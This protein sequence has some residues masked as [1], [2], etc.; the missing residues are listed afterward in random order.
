MHEV[1]RSG[2]WLYDGTASRPVFIV[3]LDY[4]FWHEI[5]KADGLLDSG[6]TPHLNDAGRQYYA[7]FREVPESPPIWMDSPGFD[8]VQ[9]ACEWA[10][11]KVPLPISWDA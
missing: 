7:C 11:S 5:G 9:R 6:E 4:D 3:M 10:Q 2:T 8:E 1:V